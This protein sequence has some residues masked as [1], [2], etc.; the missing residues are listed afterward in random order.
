MAKL[1]W[2]QELIDEL[3]EL[4]PMNNHVII[5]QDIQ[6]SKILSVKDYKESYRNGW[7]LISV[8]HNIKEN[9]QTGDYV[10]FK[11]YTGEIWKHNG[12][13]FLY[14][15]YKNLLCKVDIDG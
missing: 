1:K 3:K 7:R 6:V 9:L 2:L 10:I 13:D 5:L 14:V 11:P 15:H 8:P 12:N 4:Q